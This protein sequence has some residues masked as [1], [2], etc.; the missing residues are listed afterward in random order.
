MAK[1]IK[2][3]ETD[4]TG[5]VKVVDVF[6]PFPNT[7]PRLQVFSI[8][9]SDGTIIKEQSRQALNLQNLLNECEWVRLVR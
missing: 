2:S 4:E 7:N 8:Q 9:L 5:M 1:E 6:T 3:A